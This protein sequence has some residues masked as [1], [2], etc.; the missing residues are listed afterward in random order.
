MATNF[1]LL[2]SLYAHWAAGFEWTTTF[3]SILVAHPSPT[4]CPPPKGL[5]SYIPDA[6]YIAC[7]NHFLGAQAL[8]TG[9]GPGSQPVYACCVSGYTCTAPVSLMK[10]WSIDSSGDLQ[11]RDLADPPSPTAIP[12]ATLPPA[13][14]RSTGTFSGAGATPVTTSAGV[15]VYVSNDNTNIN[16]NTNGGGGGGDNGLSAGAIAGITVACTVAMAV[17]SVLGVRYARR[18]AKIK[19]EEA[20]KAVAVELVTPSQGEN[21]Y[22]NRGV[23]GIS[24]RYGQSGGYTGNNWGQGLGSARYNSQGGELR[25]EQASGSGGIRR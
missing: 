16:T 25:Y 22:G 5:D 10:D 17:T 13:L 19:K 8:T 24:E 2:V 6:N 18:Q 12:T 15:V 9:L 1:L 23:G 7:C 21:Q 14:S 4:I 3:D 20:G 11:T